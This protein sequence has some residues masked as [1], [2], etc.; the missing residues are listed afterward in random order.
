MSLH[1]HAA[2]GER[3]QGRLGGE[4][5]GVLV[6]VL[7]ELGHVDPEDPDVVAAIGSALLRQETGSKPKP[8]AS[9]PASSVPIE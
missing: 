4:V 7:A 5:D 3:G 2:V 6:G 8:M 1:R 9:V